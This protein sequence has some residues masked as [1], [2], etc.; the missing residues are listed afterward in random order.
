[1]AREDGRNKEKNES[2][3]AGGRQTGGV[4]TVPG[5]VND[6][7]RVGRFGT[8]TDAFSLHA[9]SCQLHETI[10]IMKH[11]SRRMRGAA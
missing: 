10:M 6:S 7:Q 4:Q 9:V 5:N 1:M 3:V 2:Q 11:I 8:T